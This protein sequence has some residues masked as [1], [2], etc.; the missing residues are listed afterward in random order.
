MPTAAMITPI[1]NGVSSPRQRAASNKSQ[2]KPKIKYPTAKRIQFGA[3]SGASLFA[4]KDL[5]A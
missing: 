1:I 3:G 4:S 5:M 2:P